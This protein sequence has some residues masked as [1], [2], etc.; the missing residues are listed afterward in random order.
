MPKIPHIALD[1]RRVARIVATT[2]TII[3]V[4]LHI[5][6]GIHVGALWRDEVNSLEVATM[7][8]FAELW[9][10]LSFDSFPVFFF[11][12]LRAFAGVFGSAND[13]ALRGFGVA[14]GLLILGAVWLNAKWL[15]LGFPL[16]TLALIGFNPMVI[17]YGDSIRSYGL[18]IL[19][20]VLTIGA[21][22]R[23]LESFTLHRIALST[24]IAVLGVQCLYYSAVLLFAVCLGAVAVTFH[25]RKFK[26]ALIVLGIG[27]LAAASLLPYVPTM[28]RTQ[29][30]NFMWRRPCTFLDLW[31]SGSETL[32][33]LI[34]F[35]LWMWS[36]LFLAVI[37]V[38]IWALMRK[39]ASPNEPIKKD[40]LIFALVTLLLGTICYAGFFHLVSFSMQPWYYVAFAAFAATCMEM[41][42]SSVGGRELNLILRSGCALIFISATLSPALLAL[43]ARQTNVDVIAAKL[44]SSAQ[45][46]DL[47]IINTW[48]YGI[49]F[50]RYYHGAA[51]YAT[52]PPVQDLRVH[53]VDIVKQQ[54][55][56]PA[57]LSPIIDAMGQTL[58]GGHTVWLI[59]E[60]RFLPP[61]REALVT[62]P[63]RD[64]PH[65][66]EGANF[67]RSW[68]EQVGF[69]VQQHAQTVKRVQFP[70]ARPISPYED[71]SLAAV[72]GWRNDR[73][74]SA[75]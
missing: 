11:L 43:D 22:W 32:G 65:G 75:R 56:S 10:H 47:I 30:T 31:K 25:R 66:W 50:R 52:V 5:F 14:M 69:F 57:P 2:A 9:A 1:S 4:C 35:G 18:G 6:F 70:A 16:I 12:I 40:R 55:M 72:R 24:V 36:V 48:N 39:N 37:G 28:Q 68:S 64:G 61:G 41:I 59:G 73:T 3:A 42:C 33:S 63:G 54:M 17:R 15:R 34:P 62:S 74:I 21:I 49:S 19:F 27:A 38:G 46:D 60:I 71:L 7:S 58:R 51:R 20:V 53:R 13:V 67:Y 44:G 23:L 29:A 8:S 26:Q 45:P